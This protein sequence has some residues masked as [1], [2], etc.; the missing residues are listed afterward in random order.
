[1]GIFENV[2]LKYSARECFAKAIVFTEADSFV[3]HFH[4]CAFANF[5]IKNSYGLTLSHR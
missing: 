4:I 5:H 3:F 1:M 2:K